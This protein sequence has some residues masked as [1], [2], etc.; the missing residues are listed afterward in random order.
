[1]LLASLLL[2]VSLC[3][4]LSRDIVS[5][6]EDPERD[7]REASF[8][9]EE[10]FR[11]AD[12]RKFNAMYDRI[13]PDAHAVVPRVAAVGTFEEIYAITQAKRSKILEVEFGSWTW[14]V[15]GQSYPYAAFV[16][17]EQPYTDI[18]GTEK[19]LNDT[20]YLV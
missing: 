7:H 5:G 10:I 2:L 15:T 12:E 6:Q 20:M 16:R 11:L 4:G 8:A 9:A 3:A 13:H 1:M 19:I 17:F 18:D 14:G